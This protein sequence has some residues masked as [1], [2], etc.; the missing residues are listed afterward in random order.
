MGDGNQA[1][2]QMKGVETYYGEIRVL[3]GVSL[4]IA[5]GEISA[6]L[7]SNGSG[8][9]TTL[10][11]ISGVLLPD[12]GEIHFDGKRIDGLD[13]AKIVKM[14][15]V[16]VPEG[17]E[18]FPDL[19]VKEALLMGAFTRKDRDKIG[20]DLEWVFSLFP[21]LKERVKQD[22]DTLSGGEQQMLAIGRALLAKPRLL[23][24]DEPSLGLSPVLVKEI[25]SVIKR[26]NQEDRISI[27]VVEQNVRH[28]LNISHKGYVLE[29][30]MMVMSGTPKELMEEDRVKESYL[31]EGKGQYVARRKLWA[32]IL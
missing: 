28:A 17:R 18:I 6:I 5:E 30:G 13:P 16:Q 19:T 1:L 9:T 3:H 20:S 25:F 24:L 11:T 14:G 31:G 21:P 22:C 15:V 32:G 23:M 27:L 26:L 2:L 4:S 29:K 7:G 10:R 12:Y 8:K